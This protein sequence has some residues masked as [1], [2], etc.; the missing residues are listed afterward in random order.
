M[1]CKYSSVIRC[2]LVIYCVVVALFFIQGSFAAQSE[3]TKVVH[4]RKVLID[5]KPLIWD[6]IGSNSVKLSELPRVI[7]LDG[8]EIVDWQ[9]SWLI[10]GVR[11]T[12]IQNTGSVSTIPSFRPPNNA[13]GKKVQL[14]LVAITDERTSYPTDTRFSLPVLSNELLLKPAIL[15][16]IGTCGS[17]PPV[18][19]NTFSFK[20][21][22]TI[23]AVSIGSLLVGTV[24]PEE[25]T[26]TVTIDKPLMKIVYISD[27][28][29]RNEILKIT[30]HFIDGTIES[31]TGTGTIA[32]PVENTYDFLSEST[33]HGV[34]VGQ[35]GACNYYGAELTGLRFG[36]A[37]VD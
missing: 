15:H 16:T 8:D 33:K 29:G 1:M 22:E 31:I 13:T 2:N 21:R 23:H 35:L 3:N 28:T 10:D 4:G 32:D 19:A 7:D 9:Y 36:V 6:G 20:F 27:R 25:Q 18:E 11:A 17:R 12:D 5:T 14:S 26:K 30:F 24:K 37:S 34:I